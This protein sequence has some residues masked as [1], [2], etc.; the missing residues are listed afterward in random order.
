MGQEQ[1]TPWNVLDAGSV[2]LVPTQVLGVLHRESDK[3][4]WKGNERADDLRWER[5]RAP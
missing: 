5:E 2:E 3:T 1:L 4:L